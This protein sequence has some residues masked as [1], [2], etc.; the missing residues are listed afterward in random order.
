MGDNKYLFIGRSGF[1]ERGAQRTYE[2]LL[3]GTKDD[4]LRTINPCPPDEIVKCRA[5]GCE[6]SD[7]RRFLNTHW[8][9]NH[10][11]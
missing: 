9:E 3:S 2:R 11:E 4:S 6:W 8:K 1:R 7:Q 10:R 5:F